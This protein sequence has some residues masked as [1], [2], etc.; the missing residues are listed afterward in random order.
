[1]LRAIDWV[2]KEIPS[3]VPGGGKPDLAPY[4]AKT[5]ET[6]AMAKVSTCAR[7]AMDLNYMRPYDR[8]TMNADHLL[9]DAKQSVLSL[10]SEGYVPPRPRD[11][12]RVTGR[13]GRGLL[14]LLVYL[15]KEGLYITEHDAVVAK[16]LAFVLT[17][18]E[19]DLNTLVTEQYLLDLE[20]EAF[21]SLCGEEKTQARMK[22]MLETGKPLRN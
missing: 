21:L 7:E 2:P 3:A 4:V 19:V 17:G 20:R 13:T 1:V 12:I 6:I 22:Q 5:F 18:G 16:K 15:L 11:E 10:A 9:Y 14:E 8:I